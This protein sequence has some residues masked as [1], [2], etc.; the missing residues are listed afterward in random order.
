MLPDLSGVRFVDSIDSTNRS[1]LEEARGG[2]PEGIVL[3]AGFQTAGR[4]RLGRSWVAPAGSALLVSV[5]LRPSLPPER[6]HLVTMAAGVAARRAC[7]DVPTLKWPNDLLV[8]SRKLA[9]IL[10][11]AAGGAVVVGMGLNVVRPPDVPAELDGVAVWLDEVVPGV[12]RDGV[13]SAWLAAYDAELADLSGLPSRYRVACGTLGQRVR[14]EQAGGVLEG[15]AVDVDD[16]GRL[17]LDTG[18]VVAVGDVVHVRP[19]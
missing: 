5:L 12:S 16:G 6:L 2:A 9:G 8:G 10:A 1:L 19:A 7:R 15:V 11:E 17:V 4:G 3:V 14:V 18:D 13:L